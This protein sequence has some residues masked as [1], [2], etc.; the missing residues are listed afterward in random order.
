MRGG[1]H[2]QNL[3]KLIENVY[4]VFNPDGSLKEMGLGQEY[5]D[6][7]NGFHELVYVLF[8]NANA[9]ISYCLVVILFDPNHTSLH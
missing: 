5:W 1:T 3:R 7:G 6:S 9:L 8:I 4:N 2:G